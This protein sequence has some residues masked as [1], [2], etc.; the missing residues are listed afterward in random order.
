MHMMPLAR[1]HDVAGAEAAVVWGARAL[2]VAAAADTV[3]AIAAAFAAPKLLVASVSDVD[4]AGLRGL[5]GVVDAAVVPSAIHASGD[6]EALL[7]ALDG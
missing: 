2:V 5:R 3:T 1:V 4:T 7:N 6:F